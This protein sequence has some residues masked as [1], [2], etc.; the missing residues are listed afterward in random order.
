MAFTTLE[1]WER[2]LRETLDSVDLA[3]EERYG[4]Q[5]IRNPRRPAA[6]TTSSRKYDGIFAIDSKFSLGLMTGDGPSYI[7]EL[8]TFTLGPLPPETMELLLVELGALLPT[9]LAAAFPNQELYVAR[10]DNQYRIFGDLNF[11]QNP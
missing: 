8:R 6:G 5:L 2:R 7:I 3:L 1:Q 9:A 10:R 4:S 11:Q